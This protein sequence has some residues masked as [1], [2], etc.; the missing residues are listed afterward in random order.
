MGTLMPAKEWKQW[1]HWCPP[2]RK[3]SP[4]FQTKFKKRKMDDIGVHKNTKIFHNLH[5]FDL[6]V[7]LIPP[8]IRGFTQQHTHGK[9]ASLIIHT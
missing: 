6:R 9:C 5:Y 2:E 3:N 8:R 7:W 4:Y 1:V